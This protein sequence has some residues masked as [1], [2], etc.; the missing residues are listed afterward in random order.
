MAFPI[1][2]MALGQMLENESERE[3]VKFRKVTKKILQ[4]SC[5]NEIKAG[6]NVA[7]LQSWSNIP[8]AYQC[9]DEGTMLL[10]RQEG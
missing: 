8:Q 10:K 5:Y 4:S 1:S 2:I 7:V 9:T 3:Y 6:I